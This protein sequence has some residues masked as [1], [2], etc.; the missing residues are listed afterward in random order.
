MFGTVQDVT[1]RRAEA[2]R[3]KELEAE[4]IHAQRM[5][6]LGTLAG[7]IA[8]DLNN[9]L[10]PVLALTKRVRDGLPPESAA[11][12][13]LELVLGGALHARDLVKRVLDFSRK[14]AA[15]PRPVELAPLLRDSLSMLRASVP[16]TIAIE[17][18]IAEVPPVIGEPGQLHQ[19]IANLVTNA[20]YA[21]GAAHG[22]IAVRLGTSEDGKVRL[23]VEDTGCG[24]S[25]ETL[26]RIFDP[27]FTTKPVGEGTGLGLAVVYGIVTSHGGQIAAASTPGQ[28][29]RFTITLPLADPSPSSSPACGRGSG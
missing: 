20:A 14:E 18:D 24:M 1:L 4:L 12:R 7:G 26:R 28:G 15:A 19:V 8:H 6:A 3:R 2:A 25:E 16:A 27:F 10:V 22:R 13:S 9:A 11:R 17:E 23:L 21:I 5:D 29:T